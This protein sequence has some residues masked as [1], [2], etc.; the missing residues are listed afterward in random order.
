MAA[1]LGAPQMAACA[2]GWTGF[3]GLH[4]LGAAPRFDL[5]PEQA[6]EAVVASVVSPA[7]VVRRRRRN[8]MW[9]FGGGMWP[10]RTTPTRRSYTASSSWTVRSPTLLPR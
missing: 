9:P 2:E 7:A 1:A 4:L 8:R 3:D 10:T 6:E 5:A